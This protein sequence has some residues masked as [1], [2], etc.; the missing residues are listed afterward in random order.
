MLGLIDTLSGMLAVPDVDGVAFFAEDGSTYC[1]RLDAHA[2]A[3]SQALPILSQLFERQ[4]DARFLEVE[5]A[6][7]RIVWLRAGKGSVALRVREGAHLHAVVSRVAL[8]VPSLV[9]AVGSALSGDGGPLRSSSPASRPATITVPAPEPEDVATVPPPSSLK[10]EPLSPS[11]LLAR[12]NAPREAPLAFTRTSDGP[13][14][15]DAQGLLAQVAALS[16]HAGKNLG[17]A[18]RRNYLNRA[19][20]AVCSDGTL[21]PFEV[22][23]DGSVRCSRPDELELSRASVMVRRWCEAFI[24]LVSDLDPSIRDLDLDALSRSAAAESETYAQGHAVDSKPG[25]ARR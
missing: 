9:D 5:T 23:L 14:E 16:A 2:D 18:V 13:S 24:A 17:G 4:P 1:A 22:D 8:S 20:K 12:S 7:C 21:D 19:R 10:L 25:E 3:L 11:A 6:T 15:L